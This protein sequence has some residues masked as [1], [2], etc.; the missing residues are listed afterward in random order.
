MTCRAMVLK[1]APLRSVPLE[2]SSMRQNSRVGSNCW[3]KCTLKELKPGR[4]WGPSGLRRRKLNRLFS[5]L[6]CRLRSK[7][8]KKVRAQPSSIRG[9]A[10]QPLPGIQSVFCP[11]PLQYAC[12]RRRPP[13]GGGKKTLPPGAGGPIWPVGRKRPPL[14]RGC[15][16]A[17]PPSKT[18]RHRPCAFIA[19]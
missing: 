2:E 11:D 5:R 1:Q 13:A 17:T 9:P 4:K 7:C 3:Y 19:T 14:C 16:P 15:A 6:V 10:A 12:R 18:I 8:L